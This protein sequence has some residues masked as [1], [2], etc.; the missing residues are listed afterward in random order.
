MDK[1]GLLSACMGGYA[2][3]ALGSLV[4]GAIVSIFGE[5]IKNSEKGRSQY[6]S[7]HKLLVRQMERKDLEDV[8]L[9]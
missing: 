4:T 1:V 5:I 9:A 7:V 2:T 3:I 6:L 8:P